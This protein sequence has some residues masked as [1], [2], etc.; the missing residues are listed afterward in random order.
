[1]SLSHTC[2]IFYIYIFFFFFFGGG[3]GGQ[4]HFKLKMHM[5]QSLCINFHTEYLLRDINTII[6]YTFWG[7]NLCSYIYS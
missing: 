5:H 2:I 3:G 1:M 6:V 7:F 4:V